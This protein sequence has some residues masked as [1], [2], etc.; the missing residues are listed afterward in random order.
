MA[1]PRGWPPCVWAMIRHRPSMLASKVKTAKEIGNGVRAPSFSDGHAPAMPI[2]LPGV[3]ELSGH[4]DV[5]DGI[6]VQL[7]LRA[8]ICRSPRSW[9]P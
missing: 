9:K 3:N 4:D 2:C 6:H 5:D 1:R 8:Q 7:P